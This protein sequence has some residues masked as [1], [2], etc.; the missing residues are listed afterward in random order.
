M[1]FSDE[2]ADDLLHVGRQEQI[3]QAP[4]RDH[5]RQQRAC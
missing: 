4:L 5:L 3:A 2:L 1:L